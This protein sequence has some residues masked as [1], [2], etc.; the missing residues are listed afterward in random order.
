MTIHGPSF[1]PILQTSPLDPCFQSSIVNRQSLRI[2][3]FLHPPGHLLAKTAQVRGRLR[4]RR[5]IARLPRVTFE[6][7]E[8]RFTRPFPVGPDEILNQL[9]SLVADRALYVPVRE[10]QRVSQ[11]RLLTR[12]HREEATTLD[13]FRYPDARNFAQCR[14]NIEQ[15]N[16][17][18]AAFVLGNV[19]PRDDERNMHAVF[20]HILLPHEAVPP[21]RQAIVGGKDDHSISS[22]SAF[23]ERRQHAANLSVE[24]GDHGIVVRNV[25]PYYF[26]RSRPGRQLLVANIHFTVVKGMLG[27]EI[28]RQDHLLV[29]VQV[30]ELAWRHPRIVRSRIRQVYE[31]GLR[32]F[33]SPQKLD[34]RV[35]E[36]L[37]RKIRG[38]V[39][40]LF[41]VL[42]QRI[43]IAHRH[44]KM[45]AHSS[46]KNVAPRRKTP[47][48]DF[49][50]VV[51]LP[52]SESR[53]S[54]LAHD[55]RERRSF[56]KRLRVKQRPA[57][58]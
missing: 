22:L 48:V 57:G 26:R 11:R 37:A 40:L 54:G 7:E 47:R 3:D 39:L 34:S 19:G 9:V 13:G 35:A 36:K 12:D 5:E 25:L 21:D 8:L 14:E 6:I 16:E 33:M 46:E 28:L 56:D 55:F 17:R 42:A 41:W 4:I 15:V 50:R 18:I 20:I 32:A 24:M 1:F 45:V 27:H 43:E 10:K 23:L 2:L 44:F 52:G 29:P 58:Q 30:S 38:V 31:K 49:R 53:I 51:P